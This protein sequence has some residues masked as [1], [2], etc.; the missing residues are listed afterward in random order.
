MISLS[1]TCYG[2]WTDGAFALKPLEPA[3]DDGKTLRIQFF[4]QNFQATYPNPFRPQHFYQLPRSTEYLKRYRTNSLYN[5]TEAHFLKS[6]DVITLLTDDP[7]HF[8]L[9]DPDLLQLQWNLSRIWAMKG[10]ADGSILAHFEW[11]LDDSSQTLVH[12]ARH[13]AEGCSDEDRLKNQA[14]TQRSGP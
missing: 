9:P 10:G 3:V 12:K 2:L 14:A 13:W 8:P 11:E 6:G 4:W 1:A 5:T 7:V